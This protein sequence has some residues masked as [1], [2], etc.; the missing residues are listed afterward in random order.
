[1]HDDAERPDGIPAQ[2]VAVVPGSSLRQRD[3]TLTH[4]AAGDGTAPPAEHPAVIVLATVN[5]GPAA[6]LQAGQALA[7]VLLRA[8]DH[9]L[10][11]QPLGQVTDAET[12]RVVLRSELGLIS[13]PQ[14]VLRLGYADGRPL[15]A[16]RTVDDVLRPV[17]H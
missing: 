16:R 15:T 6:W 8:A 11:A 10:Q 2:A 3:F 14:L 17:A 5:D 7:S 4:A 13:T 12:D 1:V 9:G